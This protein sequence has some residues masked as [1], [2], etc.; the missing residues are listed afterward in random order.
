VIYNQC[1]LNIDGQELQLTMLDAQLLL[2]PQPT[3]H[4]EHCLIQANHDKR[5]PYRGLHV[6][7]L[8]L[9]SHLNQNQNMSTNFFKNPKYKFPQ[10]F[11][12]WEYLCLCRQ[13]DRNNKVNSCFSQ[14]FCKHALIM[15]CSLITQCFRFSLLRVLFHHSVHRIKTCNP[16][17]AIS[18]AS[19]L[20]KINIPTVV[21]MNDDTKHANYNALSN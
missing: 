4:R 13:T 11:A 9:V 21:W 8:L 1:S 15:R 17:Q 12:R 6:K 2:Q 16:L 19:I 14:L 3:Q 18:L 7:C 5:W 10:K 20:V